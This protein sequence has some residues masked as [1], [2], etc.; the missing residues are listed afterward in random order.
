MKTVDAEPLLR[1]FFVWQATAPEA[2]SHRHYG[3]AKSYERRTSHVQNV[4]LAPASSGLLA[5]AACPLCDRN[6]RNPPHSCARPFTSDHRVPTH[7]ASTT[8]NY[9][10]T[11]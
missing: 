2:F 7:Q 9:S 6:D 11:R 1:R 3:H 5:H 10:G 4:N 8:R